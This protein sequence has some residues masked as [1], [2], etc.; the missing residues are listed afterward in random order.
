MAGTGQDRPLHQASSMQGTRGGRSW[1]LRTWLMLLVLVTTAPLVAYGL[2]HAIGSYLAQRVALV[3]KTTATART[4]AQLVTRELD[5]DIAE[6]ELIAESPG[7]ETGDYSGLAAARRRP[8]GALR[9]GR[10]AIGL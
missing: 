6:L 10:L 2:Y 8:S 1:A 7:L 9:S 4:L 3:E 5:R